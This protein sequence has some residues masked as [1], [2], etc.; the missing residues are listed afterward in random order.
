M[1]NR[2]AKSDDNKKKINMVATNLYGH[3]MSQM[4]P[5]DKIEMWHGHPDLFMNKLEGI[6]NT[7][8]ANDAAY[9]IEV[10]LKHPD[11]RKAETIIFPFAPGIKFIDKDINNDYMKKIK[12]KKYTKTKKLICDWSDKKN[13]LIHH[14]MLKFYVVLGM[15]V[16]KI[17]AI[18]SVKQSKW[19][20]ENI[21]FNKQ[22]LNK[23][24]NDFVKDFHILLKKTAFDKF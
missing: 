1:V 18:I 2:Y 8:D 15:I 20:E 16:E 23:S 10:D 19:L 3:S 4:L 12:P 14:R 24:K 6:S 9:F 11:K 21:S 7:P 17:H 5:Y 22:K 13:F